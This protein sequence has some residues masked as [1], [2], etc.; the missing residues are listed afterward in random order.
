[1]IEESTPDRPKDAAAEAQALQA[2]ESHHA[3]C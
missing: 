2:V 1:M 3:E